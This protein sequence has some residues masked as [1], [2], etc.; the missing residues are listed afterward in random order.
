MMQCEFAENSRQLK[1]GPTFCVSDIKT[2]PTFGQIRLCFNGLFSKVFNLKLRCEIC[3]ISSSPISPTP[4]KSCPLCA[5]SVSSMRCKPPPT[6]AMP[7]SG[8]IAP[9]TTMA[10]SVLKTRQQD[11]PSVL[12]ARSFNK[13]MTFQHLKCYSHTHESVGCFSQEKSDPKS[14]VISSHR[15][16]G[17]HQLGG[18]LSLPGGLLLQQR[19]ELRR[20]VRCGLD[21]AGGRHGRN[22]L[23][24]R[25]GEEVPGP[26]LDTRGPVGFGW[27]F[28]DPN[29]KVES[30]VQ[31]LFVGRNITLFW[32]C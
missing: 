16:R 31:H 12:Q 6:W 3:V 14:H 17:L 11:V 13:S 8:C 28:G 7:W 1:A 27:L 29:K 26:P 5:P 18:L 22:R 9:L 19:R 24:W 30:E 4:S 10:W 23:Q 21:G 32:G 25:R 20:A 2:G 15:L